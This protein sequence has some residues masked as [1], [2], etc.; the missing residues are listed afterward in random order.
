MTQNE[1][2]RDGRTNRLRLAEISADAMLQILQ[3][4]RHIVD[5]L[6]DDAAIHRAGY[7]QERDVFYLTVEH[8]SYD[9]LL[10]AERIP[11]EDIETALD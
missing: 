11:G 2:D 10:E 3:G 1:T 9:K 5:G 8:D 4:R 7:D 6:P